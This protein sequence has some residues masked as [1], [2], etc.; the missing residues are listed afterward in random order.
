MGCIAH[1]QPPAVS[2]PDPQNVWLRMP[3]SRSIS[4]PRSFLAAFGAPFLWALP[5]PKKEKG[6]AGFHFGVE[7]GMGGVWIEPLARPPPSPKKG[8]IDGTPK[9]LPRLTP[10]PRR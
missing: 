10:R 8:S 2:G 3:C 4:F 1:T 5:L 7:G 6:R 9:I